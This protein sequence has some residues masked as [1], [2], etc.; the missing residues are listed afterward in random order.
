MLVDTSSAIESSFDEEGST[1]IELET[2]PDIGNVNQNELKIASKP[3]EI[4]QLEE[5]KYQI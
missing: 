5:S 4:H 3:F 2:S 1:Q